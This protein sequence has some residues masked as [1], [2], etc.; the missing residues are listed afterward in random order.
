MALYLLYFVIYCKLCKFIVSYFEKREVEVGDLR[1]RGI[2]MKLNQTQKQVKTR[3]EFLKL[4]SGLSPFEL[5]DELM[6]V[7]QS[8][9]Q[10]ILNAGRGNPNWTA[11]TPRQA[12][13]TLGQFAVTEAQRDLFED[14]LAGMA[15][16][17]GIYERFLSYA[18]QRS[19]APGMSLLK[20]IMEYGIKHHSF[21]ADE[22]VYEL[23][24]GI[25]GDYYPVPDRMLVQ[26]ERVVK[27]YLIKE[28]GGN[29][30]TATHELFAVEGGTA[31]MC[32]L[33]E[34]L[35]LNYLLK[36]KD[37]IALFV[38]IFTPY[39]EIAGLPNHDFEV[40]MIQASE[41]NEAGVPTWQYPKE[42]LD[43]L[44]DPQIKLACIVNP[45]NPAAVAMNTETMDYLKDIVTYHHPELMIV[46][47]DV[48]G[49][50]CE[51][52]QSLMTT[53]PYHT[54]GVY[55]YSKYFGAT[56]WRLG[57][58]AL[59]P[60]NVY[61][62][63]LAKLS[64]EEKAI[65]HQRYEAL[66]PNPE[67]LTFMDRLVADSR[68]V[69]LNHTAGLSTPQQIQMAFFSIFALLD[70]VDQYKTQTKTICRR[71]E[72][73]LQKE[74]RGYPSQAS[75]LNT[76]YYNQYDVLIW[77]KA[78][79]GQAFETYLKENHHVLEFLFDLAQQEG[80]VLLNGDG[81]AGPQWSVR[82]SLANLSDE[83]YQQIGQ[84]MNRQ[85]ETYA[86]EWK[87]LEANAC[88]KRDKSHQQRWAK[89]SKSL[90][91]EVACLSADAAY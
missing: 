60:D 79:Y 19:D 81:F 18:H 27:D 21:E 65:L 40:V 34:S 33:F 68:Q 12:F 13:F 53:L 50:F 24:D 89:H 4:V 88:K 16:K 20:E 86:T 49:T 75:A 87:I 39:L 35:K 77:A 41:V 15:Q 42:E 32:Y 67:Q 36:P 58:M 61:Q 7:A 73:L 71:R 25:L 43:K 6:K 30:E 55:S 2:P 5:K 44:K 11:S 51:E 56:G 37:K 64:A 47:D 72:Q 3:S 62:A 52:F 63:R 45:S 57:L 74:L 82:V 54:L 26:T 66:T 17:E 10:P 31:A 91:T 23:V 9:G 28:M 80:V 69:A 29:P 83:A 38:P 78:R 76:A 46:T 14:N 90:E 84:A 1:E 22:W 48:Y 8:S 59:A 70:D 85:L